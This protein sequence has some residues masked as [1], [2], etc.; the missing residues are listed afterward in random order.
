[1]TTMASGSRPRARARYTPP[2]QVREVS[3]D[4]AFGELTPAERLKAPAA[5]WVAGDVALLRSTWRV[6][7][8][9]AREV[10]PEGARRAKK[11]AKQ[12]TAAGAVVVSGLA[13]GVDRAAHEGALEAG[14]RTIAVIGTPLAKAYPAE[15]AP[16]QEIIYREHLLLTQFPAGAPVFPSNFI[17]RNRT[18]AMIS[19]ASVIVEAG[20]TSGSLSQAAET[21]RLGRPLFLLKSILDNP[22]LT[23][24]ERFLAAGAVV[25]ED[26]A[27]IIE[28]LPVRVV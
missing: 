27:Q 19:H 25:L 15:H 17:A 14:G 21:Q 23:W 18:M 12:L 11:L 16:L 24:P 3:A 2:Q 26:V 10:S 6:S 7:I 9:G 1:V 13:K 8:V 20:N 5:L 28:R 22:A 4:E